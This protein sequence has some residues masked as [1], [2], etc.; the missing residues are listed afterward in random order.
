MN[1]GFAIRASIAAGVKADFV[2]IKKTQE[3]FGASCWISHANVMPF[4]EGVT[5][6]NDC[7]VTRLTSS[8]TISDRIPKA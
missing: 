7:G 1:R 5:S 4:D 6:A 3:H 8:L 2:L